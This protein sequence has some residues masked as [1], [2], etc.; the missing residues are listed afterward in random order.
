[1][2]SAGD[3]AMANQER[4]IRGRFRRAVSLIAS[5]L[6]LG[7]RSHADARDEAAPHPPF[8]PLRAPSPPERGEG[9]ARMSPPAP[10]RVVRTD[11]PIDL[12]A[13]E[14]VPHQTG[15]KGGFHADTGDRMTEQDIVREDNRFSPEDKLTNHSGDP[16]I[17][18]HGR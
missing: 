3:L 9:N 8:A 2:Y 12:I 15:S 5:K 1:M 16:R 17:G 11:V 7:R 13:T 18:T 10:P 4:D 14:Y 6:H